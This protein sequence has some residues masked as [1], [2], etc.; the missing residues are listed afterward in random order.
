M[1]NTW[2]LKIDK[3]NDMLNVKV[4]RTSIWSLESVIIVNYYLCQTN[5]S[6]QANKTNCQIKNEHRVKLLKEVRQRKFID[7]LV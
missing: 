4:R 1:L 2:I 3:P 6:V 7:K 5:I